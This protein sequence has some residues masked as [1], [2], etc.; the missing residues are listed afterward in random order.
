[1]QNVTDFYDLFNRLLCSLTDFYAQFRYLVKNSPSLFSASDYE[2]A[3]PEYH[4]KAV[5]GQRERGCLVLRSDPHFFNPFI[6][7]VEDLGAQN[8]SQYWFST[9]RMMS[10]IPDKD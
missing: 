6:S 5:W 1:M 10:G 2:V 3:P 9:L 8:I 4:R 7:L